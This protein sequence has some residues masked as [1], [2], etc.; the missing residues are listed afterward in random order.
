MTDSDIN[1]VKNSRPPPTTD[2]EGEIATGDAEGSEEVTDGAGTSPGSAQ[3]YPSNSEASLLSQFPS[4]EE[5]PRA[6]IQS[7]MPL[8]PCDDDTMRT[9]PLDSAV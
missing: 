6:V 4:T 3:Q 1:A 7:P 5:M 9:S 2:I 8:P